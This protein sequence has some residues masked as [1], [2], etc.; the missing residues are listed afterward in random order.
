MCLCLRAIVHVAPIPGMTS[1]N[2]SKLWL[3]FTF[4]VSTQ[5]SLKDIL[6]SLP[7]TLHP[8][9]ISSPL[10]SSFQPEVFFLPL[11]AWLFWVYPSPVPFPTDISSWRADSIGVL[12][13]QMLS[14]TLCSRDRVKQCRTAHTEKQ[15]KFLSYRTI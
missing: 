13:R 3:L 12:R 4:W 14:S 2:S 8:F 10:F 15:W 7:S 1:P 9:P 11:F 6:A 5:M